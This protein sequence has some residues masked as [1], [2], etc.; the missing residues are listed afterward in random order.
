[1]IRILMAEEE[2]QSFEARAI[3]RIV[4]I[5]SIMSVAQIVIL[6]PI[7]NLFDRPPDKFLSRRFSKY[8]D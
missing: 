1:M 4:S 8:K 6:T 3:V 5:L 7:W 2:R